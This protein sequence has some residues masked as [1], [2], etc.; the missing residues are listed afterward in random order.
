MRSMRDGSEPAGHQ[1]LEKF[2]R[3]PSFPAI[4]KLPDR[5]AFATVVLAVAVAVVTVVAVPLLFRLGRDSAPQAGPSPSSGVT[6]TA[7]EEQRSEPTPRRPLG[8]VPPANTA[9]S[10]SAEA[11][12]DGAVT[13]DPGPALGSLESGT[14]GV[15]TVNGAGGE[16]VTVG[17]TTTVTAAGKPAQQGSQGQQQTNQTTQPAQPSASATQKT[18]ATTQPTSAAAPGVVVR[19][20]ASSRC[21]DVVGGVGKDG[22]PLDQL[23]C[24]GAAQ[25][26]WV[27]AADGTMRAFGLCMDLAWGKTS[28]GTKVQLAKCSGGNAQKF[29]VNKAHD[30]VNTAAGKCVSPE[31]TSNGAR[32]VL[33]SCNGTSLQKWTKS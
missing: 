20:H 7:D 11:G 22:T 9:V 3:R 15:V 5:R 13:T 31:S 27:L 21:V 18:V 4:A 2:S 30:L 26:R 16:H 14:T 24:T 17:T 29:I 33:R 23:T 32:L 25:Q 6:T 8:T 10:A 12:N 19:N 1:F 28:D